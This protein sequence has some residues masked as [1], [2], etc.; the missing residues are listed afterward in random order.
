MLD[1]WRHQRRTHSRLKREKQALAQEVARLRDVVE[2]TEIDL[3]RRAAELR[4]ADELAAAHQVEWLLAN[5]RERR[6]R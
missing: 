2:A 6:A 1:N 4:A 5:L 3:E